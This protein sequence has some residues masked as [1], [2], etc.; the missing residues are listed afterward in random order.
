MNG[1]TH[2]AIGL[3]IHHIV[4]ADRDFIDWVKW[5]SALG[6]FTQATPDVRYDRPLSD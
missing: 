4:P 2:C 3:S 6:L 1:F 5:R